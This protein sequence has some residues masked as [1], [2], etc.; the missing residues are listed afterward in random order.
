M[1]FV[2]DRGQAIAAPLD[3]CFDTQV[4]GDCGRTDG[5]RP[6][7]APEGFV[8]VRVE[9]EAHGPVAFRREQIQAQPDGTLLV[10]LP[11]KAWLQ[12]VRP[13]APPSGAG[14]VKAAADAT[15]AAELYSRADDDFREL[16]WR[17]RL[18]AGE[19]RVRVPAGEFVL[20][21]AA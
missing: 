1:R 6:V 5:D 2:D 12:I 16:L 8:R 18:A 19:S 11:R 9:G 13:A 20:S 7:A 21:L 15:V 3:V 10:A 4:R 17:G 14:P